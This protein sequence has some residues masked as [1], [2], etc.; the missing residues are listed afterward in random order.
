MFKKKSCL[1]CGRKVNSNY[2]YCPSC[3]NSLDNKNK[4]ENLGLLGKKDSEEFGEIPFPSGLNVLFNALMKNLQKQMKN[5]DNFEKNQG[6]GKKIKRGISISI[7]TSGDKSPNIKINSFGD[8]KNSFGDKQFNPQIMEKK[9]LT[10]F[11]QEKL[12]NIS[13]LPREEALTNIRRLSDRVVYEIN[14]PEVKSLK[15]ISIIKL[16]NSIEIKAISKNKAYFKLIPLNLPIINY[17]FSEGKLILE[18]AS[19]G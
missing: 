12:K 2:D 14:L 7:S 13:E 1:Y 5:Q 18:L 8:T 17:N 10:D 19:K 11:S 4:N 16:E 6:E 9:L 3:G 15:D